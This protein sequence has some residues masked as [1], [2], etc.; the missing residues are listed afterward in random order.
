MTGRSRDHAIRVHRSPLLGVPLGH[1]R[2]RQ[3]DDV[4]RHRR[5]C[6]AR[7]PVAAR[8]T[9]ARSHRVAADRRRT[10]LPQGAEERARFRDDLAEAFGLDAATADRLLATYGSRAPRVARW[11]ASPDGRRALAGAS[12]TVGETRFFAAEELAA[13]ADDVVRRRTRLFLE[14]RATPD[15]LA[16]IDRALSERAP[17]RRAER[18]PVPAS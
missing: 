18:Q 4:S 8:T 10:R 17:A 3:M 9:A 5:G 12:L 1:H 15:L 6:G 13:S 2:G 16:A 14:G 7:G 11:L